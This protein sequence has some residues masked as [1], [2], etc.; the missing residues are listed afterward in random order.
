MNVVPETFELVEYEAAEILA[1]L[2]DMVDRIPGLPDG[3]SAE[4]QINEELS[5][6]RVAVASID[7]VVLTLESGALENMKRP[8]TFGVEAAQNSVG[9]L[10]FEV[11]DR[12]NSDFA[13]PPLDVELT[14]EERIAW[15]TYCFGRLSRL[16]VRVYKP[17]HLYNFRNRHGF[18]DAADALF[19]QIWSAGSMSWA[20]ISALCEE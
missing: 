5:T 11:A 6:A 3:F 10:L 17:K 8:R 16:G 12:L 13:A 4:L 19:E 20:D 2:D 14:L 9:R 7:P 15:N 18:S 1:V